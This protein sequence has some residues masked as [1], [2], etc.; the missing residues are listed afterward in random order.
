MF[1]AAKWAVLAVAVTALATEESEAQWRRGRRNSGFYIGTGPGGTYAGYGTGWNNPG[2]YGPGFYG[3]GYGW[4]NGWYQPGIG[5]GLNSGYYNNGY[6]YPNNVYYPGTVYSGNSGIVYSTPAQG[7]PNSVAVN[8]GQSTGDVEIVNPA[9]NSSALNYALNGQNFTIQPGQ[10]QRIQHDRR[11]IIEFPRGDDPNQELARYTLSPG[12]F[13]FKPMDQGWELVRA[14][15]KSSGQSVETAKPPLPADR[16]FEE[17]SRPV[18]RRE[19]D[20]SQRSDETNRRNDGDRPRNDADRNDDN[21]EG[22]DVPPEPD[23][24]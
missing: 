3:P 12:R 15:D 8:P 6:Y 17:E 22:A 23:T 1:Q 4:N 20:R 18:E 24:R 2:W 13:K 7:A 21:R 9:D 14:A 16:T 11:W 19:G 5:I 10:T